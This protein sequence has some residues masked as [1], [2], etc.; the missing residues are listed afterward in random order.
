MSARHRRR[1]VVLCGASAVV[2]LVLGSGQVTL[3]DAAWTDPVL[4]V[5]SADVGS[6]ATTSTLGACEVLD[7]QD[8]QVPGS[9][10]FISSVRLV[11]QGGLSSGNLFRQ[12]EITF[13][14]SGPTGDEHIRFRADLASPEITSAVPDPNPDW[15]WTAATTSPSASYV[16]VPGY[17]CT[18]LPLLDGDLAA[19]ATGPVLVSVRD[20]ATA[21]QT[22]AS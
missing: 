13:S 7:A 4:V 5:A 11:E 19:A 22:C 8:A 6:W 16:P 9:T 15:T 14:T 20:H 17:A 1:L 18:A 3:T 10:C 2:G 21:D 12:Y